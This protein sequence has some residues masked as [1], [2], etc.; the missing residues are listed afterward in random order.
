MITIAVC[1]QKGGV[2]K[3]TTSEALIL[4][5]RKQGYKVLAMDLDL[6]GNMS[7]YFNPEHRFDA[8]DFVENRIKP[9]EI[10]EKDL[11]AGGPRLT[12]LNEFF[13]KNP[14]DTVKTIIE[15]NNIDYD[16]MVIDT[17]P[18][19]NKVVLSALTISDYVITPT[20]ATK[21]ALDGV[22]QTIKAVEATNRQVN[23]KLR[24]LGVLIT[25]YKD[26]YTLHRKFKVALDRNSSVTVF[27]T[28]IRESQA[29]NT[30]K[31]YRKS[32]FDAEYARSKAVQDYERWG[33]EV[34]EL[35]G[36]KK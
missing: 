6:Q 13:E 29:I 25:K 14:L 16:F 35:L 19:I 10:I 17:P 23:A 9:E 12:Y 4:F 5:L 24:I 31:T 20:E 33:K 30:A 27:K 34:L 22:L 21:D 3:T 18:A 7:A 28:T 1:A 11:I 2:S 15:N 36:L 8:F 32:F 26:R